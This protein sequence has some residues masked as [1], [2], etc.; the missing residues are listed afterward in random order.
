MS[1][2]LALPW[3]EEVLVSKTELDEKQQRMQELETKVNEITMQTEYQLRLKD[4]H[5]HEKLREASDQHASE[6]VAEKKRFELLSQEKNEMELEYEEKL[7]VH[8]NRSQ[9]QLNA[10]DS[11]YQ[12][13]ILTEVERYQQLLQEKDNLNRRHRFGECCAFGCQEVACVVRWDEQNALLTEAHETTVQE[14]T[15][16]YEGKLQTEHLNCEQLVSEKRALE[17]EFDEIKRQL[18]E[19]ADRE[20]D[21]L[22]QRYEKKFSFESRDRWQYCVA[23]RG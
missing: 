4:L 19:D 21:E 1:V 12:Q 6:L 10:L 11:Q 9:Q 3:A 16:E 7:R 20:V 2:Q 18:E 23:C 17:D 15:E 22:K 14:L 13:K 8:Q 5:L